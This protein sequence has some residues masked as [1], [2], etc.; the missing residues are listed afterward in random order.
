VQAA[1]GRIML[2]RREDAAPNVRGLACGSKTGSFPV[3]GCVEPPSQRSS[4][5]RRITTSRNRMRGSSL[6]IPARVPRPKC[7]TPIPNPHSC[8]RKIRLPLHRDSTGEPKPPSVAPSSAEILPRLCRKPPV[9]SVS[10]SGSTST[11]FQCSRVCA[12]EF[13]LFGMGRSIRVLAPFLGSD[14]ARVGSRG[15][16]RPSRRRYPG[17][18]RISPSSQMRWKS[19]PPLSLFRDSEVLRW[20][21]A[22]TQASM[23]WR[24]HALSYAFR[25]AV[26]DELSTKERACI[27]PT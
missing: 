3:N 1:N 22:A 14:R 7:P 15:S 23:Y 16:P 20:M 2:K 4:F 17:C 8:S 21:A 26:G 27:C 25:A 24:S 18:N 10:A 11:K 9:R 12:R 5:T 13:L 19:L 6:P